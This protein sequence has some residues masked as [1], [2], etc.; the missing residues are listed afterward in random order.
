MYQITEGFIDDPRHEDLLGELMGEA[1]HGFSSFQQGWNWTPG[2]LNW[3]PRNRGDFPPRSR[4]A[5]GGRAFMR[6]IRGT[7]R[8]HNW[9]ARE[10]AIYE[11]LRNGNLPDAL[12]RRWVRINLSVTRNGRTIRGSVEVLPDYLCIGSDSDYVYIPMDPLTA[13]QVAFVLDL[14]LPTA[15]I[16]HAIYRATPQGQRIGGIARD[17][18]RSPSRRQTAPRGASQTSTAAYA[19]HSDAI[20]ARMR[21]RGIPFGAL[22]AGHKKDVV[23]SK[24]LRGTPNKIAFHGFY[25]ASGVP[26][27]PCRDPGPPTQGCKERP[28]LAH[29]RQFCDYAQGVRLVRDRMIV[30]GRPMSMRTVL[31]SSTLSWLI[32][33]EGPID[34]P[35]IPQPPRFRRRP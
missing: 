33:A 35:H 11:Q 10:D 7:G 22:V 9:N 24:R 3:S 32:S 2:H 5:L 21:A 19:E 8:P 34:P 20:K 18:F 31:R 13:Q 29:L 23:I 1:N 4:G 15:K 16:C 25:D 26:F 6:A 17:Y 12:I 14:N 28:A 30:D 27:E